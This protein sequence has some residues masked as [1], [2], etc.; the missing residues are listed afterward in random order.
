M[1][2]PGYKYDYDDEGLSSNASGAIYPTKENTFEVVSD[3]KNR[4][5]MEI[6]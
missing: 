4:K 2:A 1:H 3:G 5:R 6:L